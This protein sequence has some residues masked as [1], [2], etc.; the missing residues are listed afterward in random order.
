M[1][2]MTAP[3]AEVLR[4][5][6]GLAVDEVLADQR[7]RA[8]VAVRVGAQVA[9]ARLVDLDPDQRAVGLAVELELRDLARAHAG[10]LQVAAVD[11][12]ERVVELDPVAVAR[13][14]VAGAAEDDPERAGDRAARRGCRARASLALRD[15]RGV[16][17]VV[18]GRLPDR[19]ALDRARAAVALAEAGEL[20]E[21]RLAQLRRDRR[22]DAVDEREGVDVQG[23]AAGAAERVVD[24]RVAE[25]VEPA[26]E[27][28]RVGPRVADLRDRAARAPSPRP[29]ARRRAACRCG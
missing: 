10:D 26:G 24:A 5:G 2:G 6:A 1:T 18:G 12:A 14:A 16:A 17:G 9:E 4:R 20:L 28:D 11:Q 13:G 29:A 22:E 7:L 21:E 23:R 19:A 8:H 15:L 27:V 25:V 3:G